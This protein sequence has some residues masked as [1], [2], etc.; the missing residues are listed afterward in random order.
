M[1]KTDN[2]PTLL[3]FLGP[4]SIGSESSCKWILNE[5]EKLF[6]EAIQTLKTKASSQ[7]KTLKPYFQFFITILRSPTIRE[8]IA[9]ANMH[10]KLYEAL[11]NH[12]DSH[13]F[14]TYEP[15]IIEPLIT[16]IKRVVLG[17][18][19]KE[20]ELARILK[21]DLTLLDRHPDNKYIEKF[22][23]PLIKAEPEV[24]VCLFPFDF[25]KKQWISDLNIIQ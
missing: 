13:V 8:K 11:K 15:E 16:F 7:L 1:W 12:N 24:P 17:N 14:T 2:N 5:F 18:K 9:E 25:G 4:L 6:N 3:D 21:E 19:A 20:E 23:L 10:Y 22:M